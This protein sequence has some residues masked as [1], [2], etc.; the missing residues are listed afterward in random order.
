[1]TRFRIVGIFNDHICTSTEFNGDGYFEGHGHEICECFKNN[2]SYKNILKDIN[3]SFEYEEGENVY[4]VDDSDLDFY[5]LKDEHRY[6]DVWFSDYVY[7][8]NFSKEDYTIRDENGRNIVIHPGGLVTLN[9]GE[10]LLTNYPNYEVKPNENVEI[11]L[12]ERLDLYVEDLNEAGIKDIIPNDPGTAIQL[13][14]YIQNQNNR[15]V[16][17]FE[18]HLDGRYVVRVTEIQWAGK[19]YID[20]TNKKVKERGGK[21]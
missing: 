12:P 19:D 16:K 21:I 20:P 7:I 4:T 13:M 3:E 2:T 11:G 17:E 15:V 18:W 5:A 8:K 9:F 1:M 6:Y 14:D 10:L